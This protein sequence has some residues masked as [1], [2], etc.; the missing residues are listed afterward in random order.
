M[1]RL[2]V[3]PSLYLRCIN[4]VKPAFFFDEGKNMIQ[5]N[6]IVRNGKTLAAVFAVTICLAFPLNAAAGPPQASSGF[7]WVS[8]SDLTDEFNGRHLN[9]KKWMDRID[10]WGGNLPGYYEQDNIKLSNGILQLYTKA[11]Q[12][13]YAPPN[14]GYKNY[15]TAIVISRNLVKH[16][17][18]EVRAKMQDSRADSAF[19]FFGFTKKNDNASEIDVYEIAAGKPGWESRVHSNLHHHV[20]DAD[21]AQQFQWT[22]PDDLAENYHTY[23]LEWNKKKLK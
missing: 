15:T 1:L 9:Y 18:F 23:G 3:M 22:A 14:S 8:I 2:K 11:E 19:W 13:L 12:P 17:Y 7:K 20:H 5:K 16:G 10:I 6:K 21:Q 4:W